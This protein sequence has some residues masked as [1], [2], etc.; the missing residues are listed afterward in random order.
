MGFPATRRIGEY[1]SITACEGDK[2]DEI[3]EK[4]GYFSGEPT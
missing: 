4:E 2:I 1:C 3:G